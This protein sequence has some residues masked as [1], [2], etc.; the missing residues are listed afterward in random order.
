MKIIIKQEPINT[1]HYVISPAIC[2]GCFRSGW[3]CA[4]IGR[5]WNIWVQPTKVDPPVQMVIRCG[6]ANRFT[7][8][9]INK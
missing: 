4:W 5:G 2:R 6:K 3:F 8:Y 7:S 1:W 9:D